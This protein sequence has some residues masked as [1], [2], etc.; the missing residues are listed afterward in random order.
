MSEDLATKDTRWGTELAYTYDASRCFCYGQKPSPLEKINLHAHRPPLDTT[1]DCKDRSHRVWVAFLLYNNKEYESERSM[2]DYY[3]VPMNWLTT[4][5]TGRDFIHVQLVFWD[6]TRKQYYTYSV[7]AKR[8][9]HV[10]DKKEFRSGWAFVELRTTEQREMLVR[11]FLIAQLGKELNTSGQ[12]FVL[13]KPISGGGKTWFC[14]ELVAAALAHA[15]LIDY[16]AW[17]GIKTPEAA[18]P[19][20]IY[21]YLL[22]HCLTCDVELL[23]GNP[24]AIATMHAAA[25]ANGK[26]DLAPAGALPS[27]IASHATA[28]QPPAPAKTDLIDVL[29]SMQITRPA[30]ATRQTISPLDYLRIVK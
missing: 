27:S 8:P 5:V 16:S 26:I 7:D 28:A 4:V 22:D 24:V 23:P 21:D 15:G 30:P 1:A 3:I 17:P 25:K 6:E 9:V 18:A 13:L 19:H 20:H 29:A 12:R 11:S 2:R 10:Y 14:S